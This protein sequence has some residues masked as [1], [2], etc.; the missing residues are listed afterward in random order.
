VID[1]VL[2]EVQAER[3]RQNAIWGEQN[4]PDG[5]GAALPDSFRGAA[6]QARQ[7]CELSARMGTVTW[8]H[9]LLEEVA[10]AF[11]SSTPHELRAEL[12]QVAAVAAAWVQAIDRRTGDAA[13]DDEAERALDDDADAY[14]DR[15]R[16]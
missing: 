6:N 2:S 7:L 13:A 12:V 10:E 8:R 15:C 1:D 14:A 3:L 9:I 5:T 11:E 16:P 4:H